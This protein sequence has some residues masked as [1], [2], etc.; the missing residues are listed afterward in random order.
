MADLYVHG[1]AEL[2]LHYRSEKELIPHLKAIPAALRSYDPNRKVWIFTINAIP[3]VQNAGRRANVDITMRRAYNQ[4]LPVGNMG[5]T[6]KKEIFA[7]CITD[8]GASLVEGIYESG[9]WE[10][11]VTRELLEN[12][13]ASLSYPTKKLPVGQT[14]YE[15]LGVGQN[16]SNEQLK[17]S[18]RELC[19]IHHPDK[20]G[21]QEN[22]MAIMNAYRA[23]ENPALRSRY[24]AAMKIAALGSLKQ[25][26]IPQK[27]VEIKRRGTFRV[28]MAR[29]RPFNIVTKITKWTPDINSRG[30]ET[31]A[32]CHLPTQTFEVEEL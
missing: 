27:R 7:E 21:T 3:A 29:M 6:I 24:D 28:E 25:S 22:F 2:I 11:L 30:R 14:A 23:L 18:F 5:P 12:F 15:I 26:A 32:R 9:R 17:K 8:S 20:G 16:V 19:H 10:T 13:F 4:M 31:T 1:Y